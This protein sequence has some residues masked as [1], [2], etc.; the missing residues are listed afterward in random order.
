MFGAVPEGVTV[1]SNAARPRLAM[2]LMISLLYLKHAEDL[3]DEA[4]VACWSENIVWQYFSGLEYYE[5][6]LPCDA[7]QIGRFRAAIG[8]AG[9]EEI[10][11][12]TT[13]DTAV[14][15]VAVKPAQLERVIVGAT[16]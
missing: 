15:M 12:V 14:T 10:L 5:P 7:T 1:P 4:L 16:V 8:E 9:V 13:I 3:S 2:R 11:K 6:R